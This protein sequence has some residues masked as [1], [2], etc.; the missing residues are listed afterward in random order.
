M[1]YPND[2]GNFNK[3]NIMKKHL[4]NFRYEFSILGESW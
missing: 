2:F 4:E 3:R 1:A